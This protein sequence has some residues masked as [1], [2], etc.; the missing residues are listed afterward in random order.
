MSLSDATLMPIYSNHFKKIVLENGCTFEK[1]LQFLKPQR[2]IN[3]FLELDYVEKHK[4]I[5][6]VI[7]TEK[8][9]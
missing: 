4:N 7:L 2:F 9:N 8:V 6:D 1:L 3:V 5:K